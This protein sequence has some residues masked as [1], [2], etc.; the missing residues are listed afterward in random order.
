MKKNHFCTMFCIIAIF[1]LVVTACPSPNGPDVG[2]DT[3]I[4]LT[5]L[6]NLVDAP[7]TGETPQSAIAVNDQYSGSITWRVGAAGTTVFNG[8]IFENDTVYRAVISLTAQPGYTFAG[9]T[10]TFIHDAADTVVFNADARIVTITFAATGDPVVSLRNLTALVTPPVYNMQPQ[11]S[12]DGTEQYSGTI[13]W[14]EGTTEFSG[15]VFAQNIVYTAVIT[16]N[17]AQGFTFDGLAVDSFTHETASEITFNAATGIVS[18]TFPA[19]NQT[20]VT[21]LDLSLLVT[22]PVTGEAPDTT[23][24]NETQYTGTI[25]W[26]TGNT[27]F[28]G[29]VFAQN[30]VYSAIVTLTATAQYTFATLTAGSFTH[31]EADTVTSYANSGTVTIVFP[32][33]AR[34]IVNHTDLAELINAPVAGQTPQS[35]VSHAQYSGSIAW[36]T[37]AGTNLAG[38][39][40]P[41]TVYH[42]TITLTAAA[43]WTFAGFTADFTYT[44]A[45]VSQSA[46]GDN[47]IVTI[48]FP[49]T[50]NLVVSAVNV[51]S[52]LSLPRHGDQAPDA[53]TAQDQ[54]TGTITWYASDDVNGTSFSA[55]P[56]TGTFSGGTIYRAVLDLTAQATYTFDGIAAN[57]FVYTPTA[58]RYE[59]TNASG[60]GEVTITFK[61]AVFIHLMSSANSALTVNV[62][63]EVLPQY[64]RALL[65]DGITT[66]DNGWASDWSTA[67]NFTGHFNVLNTISGIATENQRAHYITYDLGTAQ[68][69]AGIAYFPWNDGGNYLYNRRALLRYDVFVSNTVTIGFDPTVIG[70]TH[71]GGGS[72]ETVNPGNVSDRYL[73]WQGINFA[74]LEHAGHTVNARYVQIRMYT[75]TSPTSSDEELG[76]NRFPNAGELTIVLNDDP[77]SLQDTIV[78]KDMDLTN[79]LAAPIAGAMPQTTFPDQEQYTVTGIAWQYNGTN[80]S[81]NSAFD[82]NTV[83]QAVITLTARDFFTFE[84]IA[85]DSFSYNGLSVS[86]LGSGKTGTVTVTFPQTLSDLVVNALDL[87]YLITM[88]AIGQTPVTTSI[89]TEQ[90][91]GTVEWFDVN[92][93]AFNDVFIHYTNY[94]ALVTLN[95]ADGYTF[96]GITA[97][98]FTYAGAVSVSNVAGSGTVTINFRVLP[99][100]L[101]LPGTSI[102]ACCW[103]PPFTPDNLLDGNLNSDGGWTY[104]Q[105]PEYHTSWPEFFSDFDDGFWGWGQCAFGHLPDL[106][107]LSPTVNEYVTGTGEIDHEYAHFFTIDLGEEKDLIALELYPRDLAMHLLGIGRIYISNADIGIIPDEDER[108]ADFSFTVDGFRWYEVDIALQNSGNPVRGRFVQIRFTDLAAPATT[109]YWLNGGLRQLRIG[110]EP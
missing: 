68:D 25:A 16:L 100:F 47:V 82:I 76:T 55:T 5:D 33:T 40:A 36:Q 51:S 49:Q 105:G 13:Q 52:L 69:I 19:T 90:Y 80:H 2:Q 63:C 87:T 65:I 8:P 57:A 56:F 37:A 29:A 34:E 107:P 38:N 91:T 17:A 98:S 75:T 73:H 99:A 88:P 41:L 12:F 32:T 60:S 27:L 54:Y 23:P 21:D 3:I 14:Y 10:G 50:G 85:A 81:G 83:Y 31:D 95:A 101:N 62:C 44:G 84:D 109:D 30:T 106:Q 72:F 108:A 96:S 61:P 93:D 11:T 92:D 104:A 46:S 89:D 86:T 102:K 45:D 39:F 66:A 67:D 64:H 74:N 35:N 4:T 97:S 53:I 1:C 24:I 43:D 110:E 15:S 6:T 79:L 20:V 26:Y 7:A 42:A 103:S 71:L 9:F 59:I 58:N 48:I 78:N 28:E 22:A 70:V 18:I 94:R 77:A